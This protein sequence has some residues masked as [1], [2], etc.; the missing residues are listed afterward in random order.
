[1]Y[2]LQPMARA[3]FV[4][5]MTCDLPEQPAYFARDAEIN[6]TGA[7]ALAELPRPRALTPAEVEQEAARGAV[8]LDVRAPA[9]FGAGHVPGALNVGLGG[10]FAI[11]A[12][13]LIALST[14]VVVVAESEAQVDEAVVRLARVGLDRVR[15][16]LRGGGAAWRAVGRALATL[17]QVS[18]R[19]L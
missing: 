12:G 13:S 11:W 4:R 19:E 8:V 7:S 16:F 1:N 9:E 14:P 10:Q 5:M 6:R 15:G 2:A 3:E 18:G 17:P